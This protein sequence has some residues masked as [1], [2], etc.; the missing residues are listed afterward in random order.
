MLYR[1]LD[2]SARPRRRRNS[3]PTD[4]TPWNGSRTR[5]RSCRTAGHRSATMPHGGHELSMRLANVVILLI[6]CGCVPP[7]RKA[8][9]TGTRNSHRQLAIPSNRSTDH[10]LSTAQKDRLFRDFER[11]RAA[12]QAAEPRASPTA[13]TAQPIDTSAD[14]RDESQNDWVIP[15]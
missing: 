1:D 5:I 12:K 13:D 6:V 11:W 7:A 9:T 14:R 8:T 4:F 2:T 15:Y 3:A 10:E